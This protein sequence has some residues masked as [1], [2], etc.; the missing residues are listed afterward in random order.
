MAN[1]TAVYTQQSE[2]AKTNPKWAYDYAKANIWEYRYAND[3]KKEELKFRGSSNQRIIDVNKSLAL[4][5]I[6]VLNL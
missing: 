2:I 1:L 6:I 4:G 3:N 5:K